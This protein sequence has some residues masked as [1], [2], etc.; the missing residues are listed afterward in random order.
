MS[1]ICVF[2]GLGGVCTTVCP[3]IGCPNG[4][5]CYGVLGAIDPGVVSNI[6]VPENNLL[7]TPCAR[8]SE[9]GSPS[10]R[11]FCLPYPTG[12]F[13]GRDCSTIACPPTYTCTDMPGGDGGTIKQCVPNN[14]ACDCTP[15][16][17]GNMVNCTI[18]TPLNT[19]CAGHRTCNGAQGWSACAPPSTTDLPDDNFTDD[20]CD[21]IDGDAANAIF[22][23]V[24]SG[25]D[26]FPG[27]RQQPVVSLTRAMAL[28]GSTKQILVSKGDYPPLTLVA[29]AHIYGGYDASNNWQRSAANIVRI[30][31][32][33]PA[34]DGTNLNQET[35]LELVTVVSSDATGIGQSSYGVRITG[36]SGPV[37]LHAVTAHAGNAT[38]G[39]DGTS[40]GNGGS[41]SK[42]GTGGPGCENCS[43]TSMGGAPGGSACFAGGTGG[44]G[45]SGSGQSQG[46]SPGGGTS[47]GGPGGPGNGC[48]KSATLCATTCS[49]GSRIGPTPGGTGGSG[50]SG[51]NGPAAATIGTVSGRDFLAA[52][53]GDGTNGTDGSSGGGGGG[54]AG[55]NCPCFC[56][57]Y[58][59]GG[60][61]GGGGAGCHGTRGTRGT[62][63][64]GS[65][66][67]FVVGSTVT[68]ERSTLVSGSG[69]R[70][71][72]GG[73]GG[74]GGIGG[75]GGD[76]GAPFTDGE[77]GASG[78]PGGNGGAAGS[79]SG[80]SG[81]PSY[82]IYAKSSS[83]QNTA[84]TFQP[85]SGGSAGVGGSNAIVG[86][87][88]G[89]SVGGAGSIYLEP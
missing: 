15:A 21:G 66:A 18:T 40:N 32:A 45:T 85:G 35:R 29:G 34:V 24:L 46:G 5:G 26:N 9:C 86:V 60:G 78:G 4:Y 3:T 71:G 41:G 69:G 81:G 17:A 23:D 37:I 42:G 30:T 89:G 47:P 67:I 87:A 20:N 52:S 6:C 76:P 39:T 73:S 7:C 22:V 43:S 64:G 33:N 10:G 65:F 8:N 36:S 28:A 51:G 84:N 54:G 63:G 59:G 1:N 31:G 61:G 53:G 44:Q 57:C 88:A 38:G 68:V 83:V 48:D 58:T 27:T 49:C 56:N 11:D 77:Q 80:G 79:G 12:T 72:N 75:L 62:G 19:Q 14:N 82:G 13:C 55:S 74:L 25:N 16:N 2:S 70:G 50:V